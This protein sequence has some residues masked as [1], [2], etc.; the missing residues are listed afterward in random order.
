MFINKEQKKF[1][2]HSEKKLSK[3]LGAE[4]KSE[5]FDLKKG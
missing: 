5:A 2:K 1:Q 3:F 4:K